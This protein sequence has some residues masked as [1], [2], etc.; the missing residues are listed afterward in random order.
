MLLY[1]SIIDSEKDKSKFEEIYV[2]YKKLMF[3]VANQILKD[4]SLSEDAVHNAFLKIIDNLSKIDDV[5]SIKTKGFVVII[6]KR[7]SINLYNK[8]KREEINDI[9]DENYKFNSLDLSIENLGEY[10]NLVEALKKLPEIDLQIILLKYSHGF[11]NKE[12]SKILNITEVNLYKRN[13]RALKKLKKLI[14]EME[15]SVSE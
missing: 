10:I 8:R 3:Y 14:Y 12:I 4:D 1:L 5:K 6:V 11:S 7:I 13:K 2:R 9:N 15:V